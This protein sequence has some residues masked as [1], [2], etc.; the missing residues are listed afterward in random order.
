[1]SRSLYTASQLK[2]FI[3]RIPKKIRAA[4]WICGSLISRKL[5]TLVPCILSTCS[6]APASQIAP[7][8]NKEV[9]KPKF[10]PPQYPN[11]LAAGK[12]NKCPFAELCSIQ[13]ASSGSQHVIGRSRRYG[14]AFSTKLFRASAFFIFRCCS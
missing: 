3:A 8:E 9:R 14:V 11:V 7:S 1:M 6:A 13:P 5:L 10:K 12:T 4:A 2:H